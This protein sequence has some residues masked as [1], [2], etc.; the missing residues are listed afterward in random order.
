[1]LFTVSSEML[2]RGNDHRCT[3]NVPGRLL[4]GHLFWTYW[5]LLCKSSLL[6]TPNWENTLKKNNFK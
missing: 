5:E 3:Q 1:M 6:I 4:W 2:R